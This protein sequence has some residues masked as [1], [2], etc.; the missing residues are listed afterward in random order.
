MR[1]PVLVCFIVVLALGPAVVSW[2]Q[3][4][5]SLVI[6]DGGIRFP[7]GTEQI[8]S[9]GGPPTNVCQTG[10][11]T[12]TAL[13]DDGFLR[14]GAMAPWPRFA[15]NG[16][17]TVTDHLTRLI[18]LEDADCLGLEPLVRGRPVHRRPELDL[19]VLH[20]G[21]ARH[22]ERGVVRAVRQRRVLL[23]LEKQRRVHLACPG[24]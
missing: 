17:G 7:D 16:D 12:S 8:T 24:G 14:M 15:D 10:Q 13:G 4:D 5:P 23:F 19:L 22:G 21:G 9:I 3:S 6:T 11:W 20:G 1:N 18:W 2:G